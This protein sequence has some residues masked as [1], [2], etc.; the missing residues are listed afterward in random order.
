M[1]KK[2]FEL[3]KLKEAVVNEKRRHLLKPKA[4]EKVLAYLQGRE[5]PTQEWLDRISL[6]V[7]FQNWESFKDAV[8]GEDDGKMLGS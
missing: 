7:G 5:K 3:R 6:F 1:E 8:H 2:H 4:L